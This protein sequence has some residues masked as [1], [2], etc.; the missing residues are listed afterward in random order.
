MRAGVLLLRVLL[1]FAIL[2]ALGLGGALFDGRGAVRRRLRQL[3]GRAGVVAL[4][5]AIAGAVGFLLA[6]LRQLRG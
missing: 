5:L 4:L 3:H 2:A 1:G 6:I